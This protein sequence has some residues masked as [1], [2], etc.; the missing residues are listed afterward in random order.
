MCGPNE[1]Q[2]VVIAR[3]NRLQVDWVATPIVEFLYGVDDPRGVMRNLTPQEV[4]RLRQNYRHTYLA[5]MLPDET[6]SS[7]DR[8]WW[9]SVAMSYDRRMW[10]YQLA[11]T[12]KQD[13]Q[14]V[15]RLNSEV[16]KHR[17]HLHKSNCADFAA[18]VVNFY[19][20]GTVKPNGIADFWLMTPKQVARSVGKY[21]REHPEA[22]LKVVEFPQL[23]GAQ[24]RSHN[25]RGASEMFLT[26]KRYLVPLSVIQPELVVALAVVYF[27]RGRWDIRHGGPGGEFEV[28]EPSTFAWTPP[29]R[30]D[31]TVVSSNEARP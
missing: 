3:L 11:T 18:N 30:G 5:A 6:V 20:P 8:D 14:L 2:G 31:A 28:A 4:D 25:V 29:S 10:G 23:I 27:D 1:P 7:R 17:Y 16:N 21:G 22:E 26:T 13:E 9:Q 24:R 19:Y 12:R 15:A